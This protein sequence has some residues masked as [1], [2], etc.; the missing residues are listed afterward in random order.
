MRK[1]WR[2]QCCNLRHPNK[3]KARGWGRFSRQITQCLHS[4]GES[5]SVPATRR[6]HKQLINEGHAPCNE[7][8]AVGCD[9]GNPNHIYFLACPAFNP[10]FW[11]VRLNQNQKGICQEGQLFLSPA[12]VFTSDDPQV[13]WG[14]QETQGLWQD[15]ALEPVIQELWLVDALWTEHRTYTSLPGRCRTPPPCSAPP[16]SVLHWPAPWSTA[17]QVLTWTKYNYSYDITCST[18]WHC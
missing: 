11:T 5:G 18:L 9:V 6:G 7:M 8:S 12:F 13:S 3:E 14:A 17:K 10:I 4:L 2:L 15:F 16:P 1:R